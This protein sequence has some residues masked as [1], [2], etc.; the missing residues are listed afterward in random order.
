MSVKET[1]AALAQAEMN[2]SMSKFVFGEV[3]ILAILTG[4]YYSSWKVGVGVAIGLTAL[5]TIKPIIP[6][7]LV[8]LSLFWG[9]VGYVTATHFEWSTGTMIAA[10]ILAIVVT[11]GAHAGFYEW[12]RDMDAE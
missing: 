9:Y 6:I 12:A 7:L 4:L 1:R 5:L 8:L 11:G 2:E 3:F 10:V